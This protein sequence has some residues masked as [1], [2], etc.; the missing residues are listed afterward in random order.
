MG[1]LEIAEKHYNK[2]IGLNGE[3]KEL[4]SSPCSRQRIPR[5]LHPVL[6][7]VVLPLS[8][9]RSLSFPSS[10]SPPSLQFSSSIFL[11]SF[12]LLSCPL[13]PVRVFHA[14]LLLGF[15][16]PSSSYPCHISQILQNFRSDK[17][18]SNTPPLAT[19]INDTPVHVHQF[20][21][22]PAEVWF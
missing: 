9:S 4:P 2:W 6:R 10:S 1:R 3:P 17:R 8:L 13:V 12:P 5:L 7:P 11:Y 19:P 14:K 22:P 18:H 16:Y 20:C 21:R 15:S